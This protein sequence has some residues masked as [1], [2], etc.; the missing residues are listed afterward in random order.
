MER[1]IAQRRWFENI[2]RRIAYVDPIGPAVFHLLT[3]DLDRAADWAE[4][5]IKER[6]FAVLYFLQ[7]HGQK[8]RASARWPALARTVNLGP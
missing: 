1:P 6:Q 2:S 7:S 5:A 8:L 3:E 4:Q